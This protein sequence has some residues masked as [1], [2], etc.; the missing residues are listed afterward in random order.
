MKDV[1]AKKLVLNRETLKVLKPADARQVQGGQ[2]REF[3]V[4]PGCSDGG[5]KY[6]TMYC[7]AYSSVSRCP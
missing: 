6:C 1:M 7:P 3:S 4:V 2:P 5:G